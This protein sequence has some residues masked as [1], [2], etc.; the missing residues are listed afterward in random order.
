MIAIAALVD[1]GHVIGIKQVIHIELQI[2]VAVDPIKAEVVDEFCSGCRMCNTLCPYSAISF[3]EG[4]KVSFINDM[5][6]KGCGTCVSACPSS[7]ITGKGF[8][9]KQILAE[10]EGILSV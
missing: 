2:E 8:T 5:L 6:C 10:L 1:G 9:D 7:A 3:D 4:K